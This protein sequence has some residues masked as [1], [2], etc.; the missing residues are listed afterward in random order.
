M[1]EGEFGDFTD[2]AR[3]IARK[4][5]SIVKTFVSGESA[6]ERILRRCIIATGDPSVK[7][8]I[9]FKGN[10]VEA[11]ISACLAR[12]SI[13][14]D[15][16]MVKAGIKTK[17]R[18]L[19]L[20][21]LT[22]VEHAEHK[23]MTRTA[24]GMLNL[25]E[26]IRGGIVA[27]GNAPSAAMTLCEIVEAGILPSVIIATPVGFVNAAA[28]KERIRKLS[29]PSITTVGTRGGSPLCVAII[30]EILTMAQQKSRKRNERPA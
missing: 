9:V 17:A 19:G 2:D 29:V 6:E 3:E 28:S 12:K 7:D 24:S 14:V 15:V 10:A 30:N 22:A 26:K 8:I 20:N 27:I 1:R 21:V 25:C 11:G 23:K 16:E 18:Q 5:L 4:S 13:V